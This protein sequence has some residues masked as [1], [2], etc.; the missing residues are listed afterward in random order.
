MSELDPVSVA[1]QQIRRVEPGMTLEYIHAQ[2]DDDQQTV[3]AALR[4]EKNMTQAADAAAIKRSTLYYWL[5][6]DPFFI[7]AYNAWKAEK[8]A[9]SEVRLTIMED[10][11]VDAIEKA[12]SN[13]PKLAYKFLKDR[14]VM[15]KSKPGATD[16]GLV[17]Q[18]LMAEIQSQSPVAGPRALTELL[19]QAGLSADQRRKLLVETLHSHHPDKT[20]AAG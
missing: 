10:A 13:D 20:V 3:L 5:S 15:R 6:A 4:D 17:Y 2:L 11:A 18:Q 7:A 8:N 14:G 1:I 19:S 9:S 12:V 16:P